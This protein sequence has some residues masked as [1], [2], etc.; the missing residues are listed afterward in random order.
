MDRQAKRKTK[1][2]EVRKKGKDALASG[3]KISANRLR[4]KQGRI[5]AR[6]ARTDKKMSKPASVKTKKGTYNFTEGTGPNTSVFDKKKNV[7]PKAE[8]KAYQKKGTMG[9]G[10]APKINAKPRRRAAKGSRAATLR[11]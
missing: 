7:A 6:I 8:E 5:E 10:K 3:D 11:K 9:K 2:A 1:I 4:R